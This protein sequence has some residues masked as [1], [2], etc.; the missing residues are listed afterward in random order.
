MHTAQGIQGPQGVP[1]PT[2]PQGPAGIA[3]AAGPTGPTG[4]AGLTGATGPIGP[5]GPTGPIGPTGAAG[6]TTSINSLSALNTSGVTIAVV[7][8]GTNVP[9]PT[10]PYSDSFTANGAN[11]TF[12]APISGTYLISY[13][14]KTTSVIQMSSCILLNGTAISNSVVS[15]AA[16]SDNYSATFMQSMLGGDSLCL[17]IYGFTGPVTLQNGNG[18]SLNIV[19]IA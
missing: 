4:A 17:Q 18:A 3:G 15:P 8:S 1:G 16:P 2:G 13:A 12:I 10:R 6:I 5:T 19:R 14:I 7:T 11:D 9:L